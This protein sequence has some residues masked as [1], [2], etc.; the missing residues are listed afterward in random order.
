MKKLL[1]GLLIAAGAIGLG[2]PASADC[3]RVTIAEMNWSSAAT[4]A[5]IDQFILKNGYGCDAELVPGDTMP[6]SASM[7]EK[8]EPDI[9]PEL[10][11]NSIREVVAAAIKEGKVEYAGPVFAD[12]GEEGWWIPQYM[13]DKNPELATL[14]GI[15]KHPELFPS[16][17]DSS[18]AM[19]MGCPAGWNCQIANTNLHKA[20][21][22]DEAGFDL[23]DPGS[24][25]GLDGSM[26]KAYER[27][28]G[29]FGYYW[30]PTAFLGKF[31]M[32]KVDMGVEHEV[33]AWTS[34]IGTDIECLDPK[35]NTFP[36]SDVY[37][38]VSKGFAER[39]PEAYSYVSN[40]SYKNKFLNGFL[41]W[42]DDNQVGGEEA[43]EK[44]LKDN[45]D[46]WTPWVSS[47]VAAKVKA[48]L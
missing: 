39:S 35:P 26:S 44:F 46:M 42:I 38:L 41:K 10:W 24:A 11:I 20:F 18:R 31:D 5:Y 36:V 13:V 48:A 28:E 37:T 32:A 7:I 12:G 16:K 43:A 45:E 9:A 17:E 27:G 3:G 6:T 2:S 22:L 15:L 19:F 47:E 23:G 40:R 1:A 8:A 34:C 4:F 14:A 30:A 21:K 33:T 25:A 29:W